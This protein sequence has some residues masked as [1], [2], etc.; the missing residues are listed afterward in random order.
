[1]AAKFGTQ[2]R[3]DFPQGGARLAQQS[4]SDT[5]RTGKFNLSGSKSLQFFDTLFE[6]PGFSYYKTPDSVLTARK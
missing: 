1:M 2:K 3:K 4:S 5:I 6:I